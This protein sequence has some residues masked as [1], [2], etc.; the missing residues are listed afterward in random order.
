MISRIAAGIAG[1]EHALGLV[2]GHDAAGADDC[3]RAVPHTWADDRPATD[4]DVR[5]DLNGFAVLGACPQTACRF[6]GS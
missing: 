2:A 6:C 1:C 5:A 3:A 4:P